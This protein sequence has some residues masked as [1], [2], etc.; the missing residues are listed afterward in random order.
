MRA[1]LFLLAGCVFDPSG[2][3]TRDGGQAEDAAIIDGQL[4]FDSHPPDRADAPLSADAQADAPP[5]ASWPD[6]CVDVPCSGEPDCTEPYH[7]C[8]GGACAE[9]LIIGG[10]GC[11]PVDDWMACPP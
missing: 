4:L 6:A 7:C 1:A 9:G 3:P 5:D 11:V 2:L 8:Y 10:E